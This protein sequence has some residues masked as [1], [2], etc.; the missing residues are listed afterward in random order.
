[1]LI[2]HVDTQIVQTTV[3]VL[4][5][6][7]QRNNTKHI[8][9][10]MIGYRNKRSL[11]TQNKFGLLNQASG[12]IGIFRQ[13]GEGKRS[14]PGANIGIDNVTNRVIEQTTLFDLLFGVPKTSTR[15]G[16]LQKAF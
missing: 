9:V 15:M 6:N 2:G 16:A 3:A 11:L 8:I 4:Q 14:V 12:Q 13:F 1:L 5:V 10:H 7:F